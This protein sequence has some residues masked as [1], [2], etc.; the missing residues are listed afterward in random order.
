MCV[1]VCVCVSLS[2]VTDYVGHRNFEHGLYAYVPFSLRLSGVVLTGNTVG[3]CLS[4]Y[5]PSAVLHL[6]SDQFVSMNASIFV[7]EAA[8]RACAD[9]ARLALLY[10]CRF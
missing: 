3:A 9:C 6:T 8:V 4:V 7:S 5:S 1:C 10:E 2:Q